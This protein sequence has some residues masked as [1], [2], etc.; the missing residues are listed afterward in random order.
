MT[1]IDMA[2][3]DR[4]GAAAATGAVTSYWWLPYLQPHSQA[5]AAIV[6]FLGA[7]YLVLQIGLFI[8]RRFKKDT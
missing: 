5:V 1:L 8:Y 6:P 3:D 2:L 7:T 4:M